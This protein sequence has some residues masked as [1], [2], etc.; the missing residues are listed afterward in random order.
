MIISRATPAAPLTHAAGL[1]K[2]WARTAGC[3]PCARGM[4]GP[5][6]GALGTPR[7]P[8][9]SRIPGGLQGRRCLDAGPR[10]G[11]PG[12]SLP[13]PVRHPLRVGSSRGGD[14]P[15]P[16]SAL[17]EPTCRWPPHRSRT[18]QDPE[19]SAPRAAASPGQ[20]CQSSSCNP[21]MGHPGRTRSGL[22]RDLRDQSHPHRPA[23]PSTAPS[24]LQSDLG[25]GWDGVPWE[26][27]PKTTGD[28]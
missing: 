11:K 12:S 16:V 26:M 6:R 1:G 27:T 2:G 25:G 3:P 7:C 4:E 17:A 22:H 9:W 20:G 13:F 18:E 5:S 23:L 19:A 15:A 14:T 24:P 21:C 10:A 8:A 28:P